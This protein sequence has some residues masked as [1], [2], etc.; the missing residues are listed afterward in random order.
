V[1]SSPLLNSVL[2]YLEFNTLDINSELRS[3]YQLEEQGLPPDRGRGEDDFFGEDPLSQFDSVSSVLS[4]RPGPSGGSVTI[5]DPF[6]NR[7]G[8][9]TIRSY[10]T[11]SGQ[12]KQTKP[13]QLGMG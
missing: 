10:D 13:N 9:A 1:A 4:A 3:S 6:P 2:S 8:S 7:D 11:Y 12:Y 5:K